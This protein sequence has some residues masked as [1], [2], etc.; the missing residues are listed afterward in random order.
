VAKRRVRDGWRRGDEVADQSHRVE[1][2]ELRVGGQ[3]VIE[4]VMVRDPHRWAV[5]VRTAEGIRLH[6][7]LVPAW[8]QRFRDVPFLRGVI[9]LAETVNLGLAALQWSAAATGG[10]D[11]DE[12]ERGRLVAA[13]VVA[14][15]VFIGL[16]AVI[17]AATAGLLVS[18]DAH[19]QFLAVEAF[20]RVGLLVGYIAAIGR[21]PAIQRTFAYHGAEHMVIASYEHGDQPTVTNAQRYDIRH[22]RCGTDFLLLVACFAV[23]VF[24][25]LGRPAWPLLVLS[26]VALLPVVAG[27]AYEILRLAG[28]RPGNP[29]VRLLVAPGLALQRLTTRQPDVEQ[30]EV[31]LAALGALT[32]AESDQVRP[33]NR[34]DP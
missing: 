4:G 34:F 12:A 30:L 28:R 13:T 26:R 31:A 20:V 21:L 6:R 25:V 15:A 32:A 1:S 22:A 23:V 17:P 14:L 27:I 5:A 3:A 10:F 29:L 33:G 8:S 2:R 18:E 9:A 11:R 16:F 19:W 7:G 24:S